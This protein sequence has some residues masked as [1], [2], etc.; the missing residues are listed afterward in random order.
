MRPDPWSAVGTTTGEMPAYSNK[1]ISDAD[2]TDVHA[3][4]ASRPQ[5]KSPDS[6]PLLRDLKSQ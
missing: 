1:I 4:L 5:P 2:L 6:I 3:Y